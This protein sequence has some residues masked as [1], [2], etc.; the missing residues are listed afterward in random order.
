[1]H[2][3]FSWIKKCWLNHLMNFYE[4]CLKKNNYYHLSNSIIIW[5][6]FLILLL[7]GMIIVVKK[8]L[9]LSKVIWKQT[10]I[11]CLS[12]NYGQIGLLLSKLD[13]HFILLLLIILT[14][15]TSGLLK[16]FNQSFYGV[17]FR[18]LGC[19]VNEQSQLLWLSFDSSPHFQKHFIDF[20][21]NWVID[22]TEIL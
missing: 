1:M 12:Y 5:L 13:W 3:R 15:D 14:T 2:S 18:F 17:F 21:L 11:F 20:L 6:F 4:E 8:K 7:N 10:D 22:E 19:L 16:F 9:I